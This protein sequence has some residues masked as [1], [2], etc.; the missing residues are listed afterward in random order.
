[1][2]GKQNMCLSG[3]SL[4]VV[5]KLDIIISC[6]NYCITQ[7][8]IFYSNMLVKHISHPLKHASEFCNVHT[9]FRPPPP[10]KFTHQN[11][12]FQ[13][14]GADSLVLHLTSNIVRLQRTPGRL[15]RA[16]CIHRGITP[17]EPEDHSS[18]PPDAHVSNG[19]AKNKKKEPSHPQCAAGPAAAPPSGRQSSTRRPAGRAAA[20]PDTPNHR[21]R[22][23]GRGRTGLGDRRRIKDGS[24][25]PNF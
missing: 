22:R 1:M 4:L 13:I 17:L 23:R 6:S 11:E 3:T 2:D 9:T 21:G 20:G 18:I 25:H 7:K 15:Q 24:K 16:W 10:S 5:F 19:I 14:N 8:N 12:S